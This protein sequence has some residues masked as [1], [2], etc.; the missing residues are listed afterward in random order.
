MTFKILRAFC[1]CIAFLM[2]YSCSDTLSQSEDAN[3]IT[4]TLTCTDVDG[5]YYY[6]KGDRVSLNINLNKRYVVTKSSGI[7]RYVAA[8]PDSYIID[9][10]PSGV[11]T[12]SNE[13]E[14]DRL[15]K[16]SD[17]VS[18]DYVVGDSIP[19]AISNLFYIKLNSVNDLILLE[20]EANKIGCTIENRVET[21]S[22]WVRLSNNKN[23]LYA[24][25]LEASNCLYETGLFADVDPGFVFNFQ[26]NEEPKDA[27]YR[28][29]WG[30]GYK[31][32]NINRV[33]DTNKGKAYITTAVIDGGIYKQHP[34]LVG[35]MHPYSYNCED[36]T[37]NT[38]VSYHATMIAGIIAAN[39]NNTG[40]AGV[41]PETKLM[42]ISQP[43]FTNTYSEKLAN[44]INKAW[45]QGAD[46]INMSIGDQGGALYNNFHSALLESAIGNALSKGRGGKGCVF[47]FA[48][49]N[50]KVMDYPGYINKDILVVGSISSN[51][52]LAETSGRGEYLDIVAPGV[53]IISTSYGSLY[54]TLSGTS[55][56]AP[57]AAG[58]AALIL[59]EDSTLTQKQV[60]D[61]IIASG[62]DE[63]W[64][65]NYG[66][67]CIDAYKAVQILR[68]KYF[69]IRCEREMNGIIASGNSEFYVSNYS[70]SDIQWSHDGGLDLTPY[71]SK[72][73]V[74][75]NPDFIGYSN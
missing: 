27:L 49:G 18:I 15:S 66:Y 41:A 42:D 4:R 74:V 20:K 30:L 47:V 54:E 29:Q 17:V 5:Y 43:Q 36:G 22:L 13:N 40:V 52:V 3:F 50:N 51:G 9:L 39:H 67:G 34:D 64:N 32:I 59:S 6:Y 7:S 63:F 71:P 37:S 35:A 16:N 14:L 44:G 46:V 11:S 26:C 2:M 61:I 31:G 53:D 72:G 28:E 12:Y 10:E 33:W 45:Q 8:G 68:N 62:K 73:I 48:A 23:S 25:S 21:D 19:M 57:Y 56:A 70:G 58:L 75:V 65:K 55:F 1:V 69:D 38:T 60:C 24:S